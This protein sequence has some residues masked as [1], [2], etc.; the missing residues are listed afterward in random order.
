MAAPN[1]VVNGT[2]ILNAVPLYHGSVGN[3]KDSAERFLQSMRRTL[4][5]IIPAVTQ[6]QRIQFTA[7]NLRDRAWDWFEHHCQPPAYMPCEYDRTRILQ[8]WEYFCTAF[9]NKFFVAKDQ[10]SISDDIS[11]V[12][13]RDREPASIYMDRLQFTLRPV[14]TLM[15]TRWIAH[16]NSRDAYAVPAD[17]QTM[18]NQIRNLEGLPADVT[19]DRMRGWFFTACQ[20]ACRELAAQLVADSEFL[21]VARVAG[22]NAL[23]EYARDVIREHMLSDGMTLHNL[24]QLVAARERIKRAPAMSAQ[25]FVAAVSPSDDKDENGEVGPVDAVG[26]EH[27]EDDEEHDEAFQAELCALRARFGKKK[28]GPPRKKGGAKQQQPPRGSKNLQGRPGGAPSSEQQ[29]CYYCN[30]GTHKTSECRKMSGARNH[31]QNNPP[32]A[33]PKGRKPWQQQQQ[34]NPRHFQQHHQQQQHGYGRQQDEPMD[35]GQTS[36]AAAQHQQ[37]PPQ[38]QYGQVNFQQPP[39]TNWDPMFAPSS[40]NA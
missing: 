13:P 36:S 40:G 8:D 32:P 39:P 16:V 38:Q 15:H 24:H 37:P 18:W 33:K 29:W 35:V 27:D 17:V 25:A 4:D 19:F 34:G 3:A 20:T 12:K 14:T 5:A 1:P 30:V 26:G 6:E 31:F 10:S 21:N 9:R 28:K 2:S 22:R 23:Q 7:R 11:D